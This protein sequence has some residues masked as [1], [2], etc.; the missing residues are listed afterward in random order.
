MDSSDSAAAAAGIG[1]SLV[2]FLVPLIIVIAMLVWVI[3]D[4]KKFPEAAWQASGQ[5][6]VLWIVLTFFFSWIGLLI[7]ALA[8]RPKVKA[9]AEQLSG[10]GA[11]PPITQ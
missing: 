4:S 2:A 6:R 5:S 3:V 10:G 11:Y 7:Y 8:I 1:I 9:A